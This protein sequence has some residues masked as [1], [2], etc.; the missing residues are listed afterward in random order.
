[1]EEGLLFFPCS[2]TLYLQILVDEF[3]TLFFCFLF[4][5]CVYLCVL[6]FC[7]SFVAW[8]VVNLE[9]TA[10]PKFGKLRV[11]FCWELYSSTHIAFTITNGCTYTRPGCCS[12][13]THAI[14]SN[15]FPEKLIASC[16]CQIGN[17]NITN[18]LDSFNDSIVSFLW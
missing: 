16:F 6:F 18:C 4:S 5:A 15:C 3:I 2:D 8:F 10:R 1:M 14:C 13:Q 7:F 12:C 11:S 17:T 9:Q